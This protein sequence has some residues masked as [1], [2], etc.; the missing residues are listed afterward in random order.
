MIF[1]NLIKGCDSGTVSM[2]HYPSS[3][4]LFNNGHFIFSGCYNLNIQRQSMNI[5]PGG[6]PPVCL[7]LIPIEHHQNPGYSFKWKFYFIYLI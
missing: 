7:F 5:W 4:F 3:I 6:Q 2:I 1:I